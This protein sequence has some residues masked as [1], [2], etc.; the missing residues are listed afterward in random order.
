MSRKIRKFRA[1]KFNSEQ[2]KILTDVT[3]VNGWF[4]NCQSTFSFVSRIELSVLK[5]RISLLMYPGSCLHYDVLFTQ[6]PVNCFGSSFT[7]ASQQRGSTIQSK[8]PASTLKISSI[9]RVLS[10]NHMAKRSAI[11]FA[12]YLVQSQRPVPDHGLTQN[13]PT[14]YP[15]I[16]GVS[17]YVWLGPCLSATEPN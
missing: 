2:T 15:T 12:R 11:V 5:F 4:M 10:V 17:G 7:T 6:K 8:H 3:Q 13:R 16:S 14:P 1:D 9:S